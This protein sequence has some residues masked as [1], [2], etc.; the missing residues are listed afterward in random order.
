[1]S[2]G[3][4]GFEAPQAPIADQTDID[5]FAATQAGR[6]FSAGDIAA[7]GQPITA[8]PA[9]QYNNS[10]SNPSPVVTAYQAWK[11]AQAAST[12]NYGLYQG[13]AA[14]QPGRDADILAGASRPDS[15]VLGILPEPGLNNDPFIGK[16]VR[17]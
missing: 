12:T 7:L 14:A 13:L 16:P 15:T 9:Q 6:G 10:A 1:M 3:S 4:S 5:A 8:N 11:A 17:R 2:G